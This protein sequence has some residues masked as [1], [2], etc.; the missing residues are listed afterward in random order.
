MFNKFSSTEL[1]YTKKF[2]ES[3]EDTEIIRFYDNNLQDMHMHNFTFIKNSVCKY[4][5]RKIIFD[6]LEKRKDENANFLRIEFNFSVDDD[7]INNLSVVPEVTKY[8]YMYIEP[9]MSGYLTKNKGCIIKKALSEKLLEEGIEVDI[10][11]NESAMGA[12]FARKRIYRKSEIY[13]QLNSNL[14]LYICYYKGI[15]IGNCEFMLNNDIAKIED[16][17]ILKNYQRKG[18]GTSVLK[19]LLEEAK[20][21]CV[22]LV[23]LIT[24]GGDT[25]KEM[26]EKC[27][28]KKAGE[29]TELFFDLS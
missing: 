6:E 13:K 25:A 3:H 19:H 5:F 28:F 7:F 11:A 8:N 4:K 10:L 27:G 16:F 26:Y 2:T 18:F 14:N 17:D 24:D 20:D 9:K 12:E 15:A 1:I 23:Y 21:N 29:K 22:E